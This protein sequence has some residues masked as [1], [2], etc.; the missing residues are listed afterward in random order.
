MKNKRSVNTINL[1]TDNRIDISNSQITNMS[2]SKYPCHGHDDNDD[3]NDNDD[4][5]HYNTI[6]LGGV[7]FMKI[8]TSSIPEYLHSTYEQY[9]LHISI[10]KKCNKKISNINKKNNILDITMND[11]GINTDDNDDNNCNHSSRN[12]DNN[13]DNDDKH[14]DSDNN[15]NSNNDNKYDTNTDND[16]LY[17]KCLIPIEFEYE[18]KLKK[19]FVSTKT[20]KKKSIKIDK[21]TKPVI[22]ENTKSFDVYQSNDKIKVLELNFKIRKRIFHNETTTNNNDYNDT[23]NDDIDNDDNYKYNMK[24]VN[25]ILSENDLNND[26][27][28]ANVKYDQWQ[29]TIP[30]SLNGKPDTDKSNTDNLDTDKSNTDNPDKNKPNTDNLGT[31]NKLEIDVSYHSIFTDMHRNDASDD[32]KGNDNDDNHNSNNINNDKD[33]NKNNDDNYNNDDNNDNYDNDKNNNYDSNN[34]KDSNKRISHVNSIKNDNGKNNDQIYNNN[35]NDYENENKM[36]L[37]SIISVLMPFIVD[38]GDGRI[39]DDD[40]YMVCVHKYGCIYLIYVYTSNTFTI[41]VLC[42]YVC[43]CI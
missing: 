33:N 26:N 9:D 42:I 3:D 35:E 30:L 27:M 20:Y 34:N 4:N 16:H 8:K 25:I 17:M 22:I 29:F 31:D 15:N 2:A 23:Y 41:Y 6:N 39:A 40:K 5:N 43:I 12:N 28:N 13:G 37:S 24:G 38:I 32:N 14:Y 18:K 11:Y 19:N 7:L 21:F 10:I 1:D 36:S